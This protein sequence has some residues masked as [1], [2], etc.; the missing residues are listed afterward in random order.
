MKLTRAFSKALG[1]EITRRGLTLAEVASEVGVHTVTIA[2]I[3]GNRQK[4]IGAT[5]FAKLNVWVTGTAVT[6]KAATFDTVTL[7]GEAFVKLAAVESAVT[8]AISRMGV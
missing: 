8:G 4:F 6:T 2:S 1:A 3:A 7:N 5:T